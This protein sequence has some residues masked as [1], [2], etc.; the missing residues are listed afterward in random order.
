ML[1]RAPET[2]APS[3]A[4]PR[5]AAGPPLLEAR[6][7][8]RRGAVHSVDVSAA[9]GEVV[10]ALALFSDITERQR[11]EEERVRLDREKDAFIAAASARAAVV[12]GP[13]RFGTSP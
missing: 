7:L 13:G 10:G 4:A 1:G 3:S 2:M 12:S 8:T 6:G 5:E 9:A 11:A